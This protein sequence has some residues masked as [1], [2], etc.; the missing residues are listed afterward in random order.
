MD[1]IRVGKVFNHFVYPPKVEGL[2]PFKDVLR[3][4]IPTKI[5]QIT[6]RMKQLEAD[7]EKILKRVSAP[8]DKWF[9]ELLANANFIN[10]R[11][12]YAEKGKKKV[13]EYLCEYESLKKWLRYW[14]R[15]WDTITDKPKPAKDSL[16]IERAREFPIEELYIGN[17]RQFGGR[18]CGL[19]PFHEE[20]TPSFFIFKDNRYHCFACQEHGDPIDY[21][22]K[23]KNYDFQTAVRSLQ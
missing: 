2:V 22:M 11:F 12:E 6:T 21:V 15:A 3:E 18:F 9:I 1:H 10:Q 4:V 19:C 20:R 23:T 7:R 17:L 14:L 13:L 8:K 16:N 5:K